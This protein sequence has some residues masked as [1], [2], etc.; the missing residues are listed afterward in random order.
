MNKTYSFGGYHRT[1]AG[2]RFAVFRIGTGWYWMTGVYAIMGPYV[3]SEAAW[4][5]A[6]EQASEDN[7]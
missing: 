1:E 7:E 2:I 4:R 5:A 3:D 6:L